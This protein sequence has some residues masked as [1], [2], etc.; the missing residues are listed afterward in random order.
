M[1]TLD[2]EGGFWIHIRCFCQT[3]SESTQACTLEID[4]R[5]LL[6]TRQESRSPPWKGIHSV[7][8][9]RRSLSARSAT[10][11]NNRPGT[12]SELAAPS[13]S[14]SSSL[15]L[16]KTGAGE[17]AAQIGYQI[18]LLLDEGFIEG[19]VVWSGAGETQVPAA[20]HV[21]RITMA[22]HDYPESVRDPKVWNKTKSILEK[23]RGG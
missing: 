17:S 2:F 16:V 21:K 13:G 10:S 19:K 1:T 5:H 8:W 20:Y 6:T 3:N 9:R 15:S 4:G 18:Q 12:S 23:R 14:I 11:F 7:H 22:G